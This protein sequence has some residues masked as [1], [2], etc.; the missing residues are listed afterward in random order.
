MS[1][2]S[3]EQRTSHGELEG[4]SADKLRAA[5]LTE[6]RPKISFRIS[7]AATASESKTRAIERIRPV[8]SVGS[9]S[10]SSVRSNNL[11]FAR[12]QRN[13]NRQWSVVP[14]FIVPQACH[15]SKS[16]RCAAFRKRRRHLPNRVA[17]KLHGNRVRLP[18]PV[19]VRPSVAVFLD[20]YAA[21]IG[22]GERATFGGVEPEF[23]H[24]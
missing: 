13:C 15:P 2:C 19:L 8:G 4:H 21:A 16:A 9:S 6:G 3:H 1:A 14:S 23:A 11:C 17:I 18:P 12:S 22:R 10:V 7:R 20:L 5:Y 24:T